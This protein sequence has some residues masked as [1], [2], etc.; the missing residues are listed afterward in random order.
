MDEFILLLAF[1]ALTVGVSIGII[2]NNT[3]N[4][5][6]TF[7]DVKEI[8]IDTLETIINKSDTTYIVQININ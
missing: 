3:I 5:K 7:Y 4:R 8:N 2:A 6:S 1:I